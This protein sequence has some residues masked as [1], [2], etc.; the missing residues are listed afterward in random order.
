M[1]NVAIIRLA[2]FGPP[3]WFFEDL[4]NGIKIHLTIAQPSPVKIDLSELS[5]KN[6]EYV[7]ASVN[8]GAIECTNL[9][10]SELLEIVNKPKKE[11]KEEDSQPKSQEEIIKE[12]LEKKYKLS[13]IKRQERSEKFEERC[14]YIADQNYAAIRAVMANEK[15]MTVILGVLKY[16]SANKNRKTVK[17]FLRNKAKILK[18][19]K[20]QEFSKEV[21]KK[22][23]EVYDRGRVLHEEESPEYRKLGYAPEEVKHKI[24]VS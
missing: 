20:L 17:D 9:K 18:K 11:N 24:I 6:L 16:E 7:V 2:E 10:L 23:K 12:E 4:E 19:G 1:S 13:K 8:S 21:E 5:Q 3:M 15:E 14:Q 22:E